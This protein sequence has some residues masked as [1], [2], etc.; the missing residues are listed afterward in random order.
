MQYPNATHFAFVPAIVKFTGASATSIRLS[1]QGDALSGALIDE[2][3]V[4]NGGCVFDIQRVLQMAFA[5][6]EHSKIAYNEAF[7]DSPLKTA[8]TVAVSIQT[9]TTWNQ[10]DSFMI[11]A[12]WGAISA[13]ESS[14]GVMLR[15]WFRHF[16]FTVDIFAK[17]GTSFDIEVDRGAA[18]IVFYSQKEDAEGA[19]PYHRYLMNPAKVL[20]IATAERSV[21]I[22]V[23]HSLVLKNDEESVGLVAYTLELDCATKGLYLRWIDRQGRYCYY[24]FRSLGTADANSVALAWEQNSMDVP[25]AYYDGVNNESPARQSLSTRHTVSLGARLVDSETF[26]FLIS[27]TTSP[28]VDVFDGYDA[29]GAPTWHRVNVVAVSVSKTTAHYQDFTM[30][31]EEPKTATQIL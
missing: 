3:A 29:D 31:I 7:N 16:P 11:D 4:F 1:I 6:V 23:P 18:E 14:G 15:K 2:R 5:N 30:S 19:T 10:V 24:L 12:I 9:G 25:T 21:H 22:A 20:D 26:D 8:L 28:V 27:A 13:R 17:N